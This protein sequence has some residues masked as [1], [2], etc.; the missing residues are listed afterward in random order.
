MLVFQLY[1]AKTGQDEEE[2][3]AKEKQPQSRRVQKNQ[4]MRR[5]ESTAFWFHGK[6]NFHGWK[7]M[8]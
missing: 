4:T 1:S 8:T 2:G 7:M 6:N 3:T 5:K